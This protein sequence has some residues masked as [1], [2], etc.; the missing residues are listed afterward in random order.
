MINV[1]A[2]MMLLIRPI[3]PANG[4]NLLHLEPP[5]LVYSYF[6]IEAVT[7]LLLSMYV[8]FYSVESTRRLTS[9]VHGGLNILMI[10]G[11]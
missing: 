6:E 8:S 9:M 1:L 4:A 7:F 10:T 5:G 11:I 2:A 3:I